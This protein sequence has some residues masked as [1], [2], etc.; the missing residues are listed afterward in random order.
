VLEKDER[1]VEPEESFPGQF[2]G[3]AVPL[4]RVPL[5]VVVAVAVTSSNAVSVT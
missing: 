1:P 2:F 5:T 3:R 4:H